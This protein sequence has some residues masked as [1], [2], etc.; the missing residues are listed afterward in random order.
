MPK[1]AKPLTDTQARTAKPKEKAYTLAD[2][3]GMYLEVMPS[4]SKA[5]RMAYMPVVAFQEGRQGGTVAAIHRVG[6]GSIP[7]AARR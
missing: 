1:L 4:G 5:W 6:R 7:C 2:G 3:G